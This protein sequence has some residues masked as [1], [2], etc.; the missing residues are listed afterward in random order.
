MV[1]Q[2]PEGNTDAEKGSTVSLTVS[3]G[4]PVV[5]VPE[6]VG[7]TEEDARSALG[8]AGFANIRTELIFDEDVAVGSVV[9]QDP[10]GGQ[11]APLSADITLRVSQGPEEVVVPDLSG[12]TA[13]E[14]EGILAQQGLKAAQQPVEDA[15]VPEGTVIRTDPPAGTVVEKG[16]TITLVVSAGPEEIIVPSVTEKTEETAR[17]ELSTAGF[18]VEVVEQPL[19]PGDADDGRVLAQD[20]A[21]G[22]RATRGSTVTITVGRAPAATT[23]STTTTTQP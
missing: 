21:G 1:S 17:S 5:P 12:R 8:D 13:A 6:V 22:T 15:Q 23:S 7:F 9:E 11:E 3:N 16:Q 14:A 2:D 18:Q 4:E 19:P 20:P 10:A